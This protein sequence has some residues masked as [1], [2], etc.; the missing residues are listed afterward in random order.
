VK[1]VVGVVFRYET[2]K[3]YLVVHDLLSGR[4]GKFVCCVAQRLFYVLTS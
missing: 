2:V 3:G 4:F 1:V